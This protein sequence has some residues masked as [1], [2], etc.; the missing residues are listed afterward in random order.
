MTSG[1]MDE[2]NKT[3]MQCENAEADAN[4]EKR[5]QTRN[6]KQNKAMNDQ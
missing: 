2:H 4:R 3:C 1:D 6:E 5:Y